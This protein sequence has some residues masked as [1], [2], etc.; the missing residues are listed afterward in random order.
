MDMLS[1]RLLTTQV[2]DGKS[3]DK[4]S[5]L[6]PESE[7]QLLST[8]DNTKPANSNGGP[9]EG[10]SVSGDK[11]LQGDKVSILPDHVTTNGNSGVVDATQNKNAV[12]LIQTP[13]KDT[14]IADAQVGD[15][16]AQ[17]TTDGKV[18]LPNG[19]MPNGS[20]NDGVLGE[21]GER[22]GQS[23][24]HGIVSSQSVGDA[25]G[26][27]GGMVDAQPVV[28]VSDYHRWYWTRT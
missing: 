3:L 19:P 26:G 4:T 24:Q 18:Q 7:A 15:G 1:V 14:T 6:Q 10:S 25:A 8:N 11:V 5:N 2:G 21:K 9:V 12:H 23:G 22:P 17:N 13:G 20:G 28:E 27:K 16:S